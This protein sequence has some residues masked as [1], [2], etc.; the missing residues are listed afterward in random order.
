MSGFSFFN[1]KTLAITYLKAQYKSPDQAEMLQQLLQACQ[2]E[3]GAAWDKK[4]WSSRVEKFVIDV[5]T[6]IFKEDYSDSLK[7]A[8][9]MLASDN[10]LTAEPAR[11]YSAGG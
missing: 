10:P 9:R 2:R 1:K 6:Q 4:A 8:G 11:G 7:Y 5:K 3:F